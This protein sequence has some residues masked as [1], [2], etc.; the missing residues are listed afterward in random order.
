MTIDRRAFLKYSATMRLVL[1]ADEVL[2]GQEENPT[3]AC[4]YTLA[5]DNLRLRFDS[6]GPVVDR[7]CS[8]K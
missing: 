5:N 4:C 3:E 6:K 2:N 8:P 7:G 1:A